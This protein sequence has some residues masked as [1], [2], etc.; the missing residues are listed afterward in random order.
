[1]K[2]LLSVD[3]DYFFPVPSPNKDKDFLYDWGHIEDRYST[4]LMNAI[5]TVRAAQF[6]AKGLSLPQTSGEELSFWENFDLSGTNTLYFADSHVDILQ[7]ELYHNVTEVFNF[8][9]HHDAYGK[10]IPGAKRS[11]ENWTFHFYEKDAAL[12]TVLPSWQDKVNL[13]EPAIPMQIIQGFNTYKYIYGKLKIDKLFVCLSG[14]WVPPWLDENFKTFLTSAE[15][16]NYI[17]PRRMDRFYHSLFN[18]SDAK[19]ISEKLDYG[20]PFDIATK[21]KPTT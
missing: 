6:L 12:T 5:W 9:A 10:F 1:M 17:G 2:R 13:P 4:G 14:S 7:K 11:C 15:I 18:L 8:D 3:W 21:N 19:I 20:K 16:E